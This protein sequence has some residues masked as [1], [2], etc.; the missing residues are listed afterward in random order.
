VL[1]ALLREVTNKGKAEIAY[2]DEITYGRVAL[3]E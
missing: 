1:A 2:I 3:V